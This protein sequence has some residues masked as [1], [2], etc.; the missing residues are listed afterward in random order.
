ML[1]VKRGSIFLTNAFGP[2]LPTSSHQRSWCQPQHQ[3]TLISLYKWWCQWCTRS[4]ARL[5]AA[6]NGW[7]KT[8]PQLKCSRWHLAR[9]LA[10]WHK[11]MTRQG[12]RELTPFLS[13]LTT[14]YP[15]SP[16]ASYHIC[17]R[18]CGFPSPENGPPLHSNY[19][20]RQLNQISGQTLD[21]NSQPH[22]FQAYVEQC[23]QHK[24]CAV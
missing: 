16:R 6:T 20:W 3:H 11:A 18:C 12:N 2:N 22:H 7:W 24:R 21:K 17:A 14:K 13:W 8:Q 19:C 4:Q 9:I 10:A 1:S 15:S 23:P 5:S